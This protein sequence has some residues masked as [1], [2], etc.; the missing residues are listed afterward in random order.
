MT[1][2]DLGEK[3]GMTKATLSRIETGDMALTLDAARR[4]SAATGVP[5]RELMPEVAKEFEPAPCQP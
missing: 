4:I 2:A 3:V 1:L 5:L